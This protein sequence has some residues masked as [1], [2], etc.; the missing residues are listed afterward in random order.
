MSTRRLSLLVSVS[1]DCGSGPWQLRLPQVL[2]GLVQVPQLHCASCGRQVQ[3]P[4]PPAEEDMPKITVHGGATNDRA[5]DAPAAEPPAE[6]PAEVT[7][8][9]HVADAVGEAL[10]EVA[11]EAYAEGATALTDVDP[12]AG[13]TLTELRELA[14]GRGVASYGTKAQITERLRAADAEA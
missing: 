2:T 6:P 5:P 4:W 10:P 3:V 11:A 12:Y 13:K 1:C 7:V 9:L 8:E 14:D